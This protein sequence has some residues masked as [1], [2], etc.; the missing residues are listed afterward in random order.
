[1]DLLDDYASSSDNETTESK[2][3][4]VSSPCSQTQTQKTQ[5]RLPSAASLFETDTSSAGTMKRARDTSSMTQTAKSMKTATKKT[6]TK[7]ATKTIVP[8][9]V[10]SKRANVPTE[11]L[12]Y[13]CCLFCHISSMML[14]YFYHDMVPYRSWT[15]HKSWKKGSEKPQP[16]AKK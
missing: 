12:K 2:P 13:E 7:A 5:S 14:T 4:P 1:M 11:D 15:T 9:Q 10:A 8:N 3:K 6:E 16:Q